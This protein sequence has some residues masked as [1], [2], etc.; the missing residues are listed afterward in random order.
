MVSKRNINKQINPSASVMIYN[1]RD[2]LGSKNLKIDENDTDQVI[3]NTV[4]LISVTTQKSK[5]NPAGTFEFHLA[6]TKNW[7]TAITPGSWCVILMGRTPIGDDETKY[8]DPKVKE[9]HFKMLGKIESVRVTT[10]I[11]QATGAL[12][13]AYVVTG[14]DWGHIFNSFLYVDPSAVT[15]E[16]AAIT[17]A[18]TMLYK[19][20]VK[21]YGNTEK[22]QKVKWHSTNAIRAI[23]S[24][25]GIMDPATTALAV[26]TQDKTLA[27]ALNSFSIP[28]KL[29]NYM[30]FTNLKGDTATAITQLLRIRTGVLLSPDVYSGIDD[31]DDD[32]TDGTGFLRPNSMLGTHTIWQLMMDNCNSIL[33]EL[34]TDIRFEDGKP[35]LTIYKR[36]KPFAIR[37]FSDI[38]K[39]ETNIGEGTPPEVTDFAQNFVSNF[40]DIKQIKI[41]KED[42]IN[43]NAG[44]NWRDRY[45]FIQI[46]FGRQF[47]S[48]E[49]VVNFLNAKYREQ[50]QIFDRES[51]RRDGLMPMQLNVKYIPPL[52]R[53]GKKGSSW[54]RA[55]QYKYLAKEWYFD[56]H[57]MLNGSLTMVGQDKYIQVGDNIIFPSTVISPAQ[58]INKD[59]I[60]NKDSAYLLAHVESISHTVNVNEDG[61]RSFISNINFVRGIITNENGES[62]SS[63]ASI[64]LDQNAKILSEVDELN[65]DRAFGTS[66]DL[67]PDV[68]RLKGK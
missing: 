56:T 31:A 35:L 41:P 17:T 15:P 8:N 28:D 53:G 46:N 1:Y 18:Q 51:I 34:V 57:K 23:L 62:L 37:E 19:N 50:S 48:D 63:T 4:S 58:N 25:W 20:I 22:Q 61:A 6:P 60:K 39:Y 52:E 27:K 45:N 43:I 13:T 32:H 68:Q 59:S 10:E 67:D 66:T 55:N 42:I 47:F 9:E 36:V 3:L 44:T 65:T 40:K 5:S 7:V 64:T 29:S 12:K 26:L 38:V 11:D 33:N 2:R 54:V 21:T 49:K 24:F 16:D 14:K 30:G